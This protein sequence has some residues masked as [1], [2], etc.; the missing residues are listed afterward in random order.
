M[1]IDPGWHDGMESSST[2]SDAA[3]DLRSTTITASSATVRGRMAQLLTVWCGQE[4]HSQ[5]RLHQ[6]VP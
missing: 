5:Q 4:P 2:G 1:R 3:E 6:V